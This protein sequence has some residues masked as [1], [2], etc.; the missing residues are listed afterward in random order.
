MKRLITLLAIFCLSSSL[1]GCTQPATVLTTEPTLISAEVIRVIDGDTIEVNLETKSFKVRY[2][3]IDTP[4][5]GEPWAD[6]ATDKNREL[7]E[8]ETIWLEKDISETDK[9]GRLLRY[10]FVEDIFVNAE[11][12][13]E[14]LAE[15]K[16][17]APDIKYY[18]YL[19]ELQRKAQAEKRG[20]WQD[21]TILPPPC[22]PDLDSKYV[23][24]INSNVY[25]YPDC[26][27]VQRIKP[28]NKI[29]FSSSEDARTHGYRPC[30]VCKPP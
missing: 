4:E 29:W 30:K 17:Y 28:E 7:V 5:I 11:L 10:I 27:Y 13:R 12:V 1:I 6:E 2:I 9:Y 23:G 21:I 16:S 19:L 26:R 15:A 8:D 25:H 3:G 14:G 20:M 24:S 22:E 18:D